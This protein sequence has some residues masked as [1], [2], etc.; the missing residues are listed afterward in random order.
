[1]ANAFKKTPKNKLALTLM[2]ASYILPWVFGGDEEAAQTVY[3][4]TTQPSSGTKSVKDYQYP[5]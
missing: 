4:V 1:M 3:Q 2:A 5:I